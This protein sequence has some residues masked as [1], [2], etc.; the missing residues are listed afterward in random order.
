[1][2][3]HQVNDA[4]ETNRWAPWWVY[5]VVILG[6]N[7]LRQVVMPAGTLPE[8]AVVLI[9]LVSSAFLFGAITVVY[10]ASGRSDPR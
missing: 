3:E 4:K 7:S 6:V 5:L 8:W 9:A 10:R 1:M 2:T